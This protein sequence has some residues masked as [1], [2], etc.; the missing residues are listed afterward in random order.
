MSAQREPADPRFFT[1]ISRM[2]RDGQPATDQ[3]TTTADSNSALLFALT[4]ERLSIYYEHGT[5]LTLAQT[6]TVAAEWLA[7]SGRQLALLQRKHLSALSDELARQ[8][9]GSVSREAGLH[10]SH[11]MTES[12]DGRYQSDIGPT[13]HEECNRL[14]TESPMP[15]Q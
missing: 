11:E 12:L 7:R 2:Y 8:I 6:T 5:W 4:A 14:L 9:A 13:L 15:E 3:K 10:I 1:A